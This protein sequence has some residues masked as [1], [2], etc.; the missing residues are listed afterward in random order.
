MDKPLSGRAVETSLQMAAARMARAPELVWPVASSQHL[1][2]TWGSL[3]LSHS[4][5]GR[6]CCPVS[7]RATAHGAPGP[8]VLSKRTDRVSPG[9]PEPRRHH[10]GRSPSGL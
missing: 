10:E 2:G 3:S 8:V 5:G 9:P 4:E 1:T 6:L 7:G